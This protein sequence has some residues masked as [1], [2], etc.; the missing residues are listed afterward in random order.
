M[1]D[2]RISPS[3]CPYST[4]KESVG[5]LIER[6]VEAMST[7]PARWELVLVDDGSADRTLQTARGYLSRPGLDLKIV[8]LQ[9]NFRTDGCHAGRHRHGTRPADRHA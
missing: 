6:I 4:K 5:P 9:R 8:E 2:A 1:V 3:W 7:F